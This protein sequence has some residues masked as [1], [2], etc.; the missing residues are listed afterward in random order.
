MASAC[1][2]AAGRYRTVIGVR[3][4]FCGIRDRVEVA[5]NCQMRM[6]PKGTGM[7]I[8]MTSLMTVADLMEQRI[9]DI[10][11][12]L[13]LRIEITRMGTD[14]RVVTGWRIRG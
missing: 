12:T 11:R 7:R 10:V 13:G 4:V 1:M 14:G 3:H 8:E 5:S 2:G 6:P 9:H